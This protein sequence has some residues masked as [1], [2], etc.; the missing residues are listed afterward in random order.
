M[1]EGADPLLLQRAGLGRP[2]TGDDRAG[3]TQLPD[4]LQ[5]RGA[6]L[7][8][9]EAEHP[10][11]PRAVAEQPGG[12]GEHPAALVGRVQGERE[13]RQRAVVGDRG[14]EGRLVADPG[15][16]P[17][18]DRH[19]H[20]E[21][22]RE[23]GARQQQLTGVRAVDGV[24]HRRPDPPDGGGRVRPAVGED[25]GQP[26]VLTDGQQLGVLLVRPA[27]A[28]SPHPVAQ[29]GL[30]AVH[31]PDPGPDV[32]RQLR[33][34][35]QGEL[36]VQHH[37]GG[38]ADQARPGGAGADPAGHPDRQVEGVVRDE[39]LEQDERAE[40]ADPSAGLHATGDQ[41]VR[42]GRRRGPRLV[43]AGHLHQHP[44]AAGEPGQRPGAARLDQHQV[45]PAG[46]GAVHVVRGGPAPRRHPDAD[47][48][49]GP[50]RGLGE[51][52][53]RPVVAAGQ[54]DDAPPATGAGGGRDSW[55]R[56]ED[57]DGIDNHDQVARVRCSTHQAPTS[58][59]RRSRCD[60]LD[61]PAERRRSTSESAAVNVAL[62]H[63]IAPLSYAP[64]KSDLLDRRGEDFLLMRRDMSSGWPGN[65]SE[66]SVRVGREWRRAGWR[67]DC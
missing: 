8:G 38:T 13:E 1:Q 16:R 35:H 15:H 47:R 56:F 28:H 27:P 29:D 58:V 55:A 9:G 30:R 18:G 6:Q 41:P 24:E 54:V 40:V 23:G 21:R 22:L 52:A 37:P 65:T 36:G 43:P 10:D 61:R 42:A 3:G 62:S 44:V 7:L 60:G 67:G 66:G 39:L 11:T 64:V 17:L 46:R 32:R 31:P 49:G 25:P 4:D 5:L 51:R 33:L 12:L 63:N 26:P 34:G 19:P 57:A 20:P 14:G 2:A 48:R 59:A 50:G 45:H 53:Q